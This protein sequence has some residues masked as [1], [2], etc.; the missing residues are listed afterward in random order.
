MELKKSPKADLECKKTTFFLIGLAIALLVVFLAFDWSTAPNKVNN[1]GTLNSIE[2]EEEIIPITR[3][4]EIKPPPPP[5][6]PKVVEVLNIGM[7][8]C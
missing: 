2:V 3:E 4:Q 7:T 1:L 8:I 6:P 5:P